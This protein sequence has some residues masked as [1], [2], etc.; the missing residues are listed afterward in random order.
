MQKKLEKQLKR[1]GREDDSKKWAKNNNKN[2]DKRAK[3]LQK[4]Y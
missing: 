3:I 4:N 2:T 1:T